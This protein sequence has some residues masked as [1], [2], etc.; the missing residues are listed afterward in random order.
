MTNTTNPASHGEI[1]SEA[2]IG[3]TVRAACRLALGDQDRA[4]WRVVRL[5][6]P[7]QAR[8]IQALET[9]EDRNTENQV[10]QARTGACAI[11]G[12]R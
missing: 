4:G 1:P 9:P 11:G 5:Q 7:D 3:T 10:R 2:A 12:M 8:N 6:R